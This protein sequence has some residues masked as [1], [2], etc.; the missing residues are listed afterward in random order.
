MVCSAISSPRRPTRATILVLGL[1]AFVGAPTP[2]EASPI[3]GHRPMLD[4]VRT[5]LF[6]VRDPGY[7]PLVGT[8][9]IRIAATK[10]APATITTPTITLYAPPVPAELMPTEPEVSSEAAEPTAAEPDT[11]ST[12]PPKPAPV[13]PEDFIPYFQLGEGANPGA[14]SSLRFTPARPAL[15]QSNAEYRQQ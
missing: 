13:R 3:S 10:P 4:R 2:A 11:A 1:M 7:L 15:P 9:G 14:E 6:P 5:A 12:N 8:H